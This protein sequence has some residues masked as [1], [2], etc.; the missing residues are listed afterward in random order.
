MQ[1][2][3]YTFACGHPETRPEYADL[4]KALLETD[5]LSQDQRSTEGSIRL[6]TLRC[7]DCLPEKDV[8]AP[9][10]HLKR[11]ESRRN[12]KPKVL[13]ELTP[14]WLAELCHVVSAWQLFEIEDGLLR[15]WRGG[16]AFRALSRFL[17]PQ[18]FTDPFL[19]ALQSVFG[20]QVVCQAIWV[21]SGWF[22]SLMFHRY[23]ASH[24]LLKLV[25]TPPTRDYYG[26]EQAR[27]TMK[28]VEIRLSA[29]KTDIT[30]RV[31]YMEN[32]DF[33]ETGLS[34]V[35]REKLRKRRRKDEERL[36]RECKALSVI[37]QMWNE[38][39]R[40]P[41]PLNYGNEPL[42]KER[43]IDEINLWYWLACEY[44]WGYEE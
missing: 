36:D 43:K 41:L 15:V 3:I 11:P 21:G 44:V 9:E 17:T 32:E 16:E 6:P 40:S 18:Q 24:E 5:I 1:N 10:P 35:K 2:I 22:C 8:Y 14:G 31:L 28:F 29:A 38:I 13:R 4:W 34:D 30:E 20:F 23:R 25:G 19:T 27:E 33:D 12:P 39:T 37:T 42:D 7:N 26:P